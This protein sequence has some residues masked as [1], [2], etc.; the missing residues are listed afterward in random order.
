EAVS[1]RSGLL[2]TVGWRIGEETAYALEGSVFI[3]GA[4]F[5]WL[6][7]ELQL[8]ASAREV[9]ELAATVEDS[10]GCVLVPAFA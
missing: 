9:D 4:L 10:G 2:T 3:G 5:Q 7:D 1:S 6:R 8:V